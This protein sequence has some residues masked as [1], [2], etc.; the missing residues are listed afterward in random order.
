MP[1][2]VIWFLATEPFARTS[3]SVSVNHLKESEIRNPKGTDDTWH[4]R[5]KRPVYAGPPISCG[6]RTPFS[7]AAGLRFAERF[8]TYFNAAIFAGNV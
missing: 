3:R 7:N 2:A 8:S 4:V 1:D 5:C 6:R